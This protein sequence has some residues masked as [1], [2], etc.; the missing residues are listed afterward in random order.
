MPGTPVSRSDAWFVAAG[1]AL[2]VL[3]GVVALIPVAIVVYALHA[4]RL[5]DGEA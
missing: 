1:V 2:I 5:T 3:V 4:N